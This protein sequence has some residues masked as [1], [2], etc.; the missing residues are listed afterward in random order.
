M[1]NQKV[2]IYLITDL[3]NNKQYVGQTNKGYKY[4]FKQHCNYALGK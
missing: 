4:R 3:I 1:T 2:D